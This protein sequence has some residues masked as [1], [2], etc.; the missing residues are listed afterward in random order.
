MR[1]VIEATRYFWRVAK[2]NR[3]GAVYM[4]DER[5]LIEDYIKMRCS[6]YLRHHTKF[7]WAWDESIDGIELPPFLLLPLVENAIK[8]GLMMRRGE[9]GALKIIFE[10]VPSGLRTRDCKHCSS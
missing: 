5:E 7:E 8:H 9:G 10:R 6:K 4:S 3:N 2:M 1:T